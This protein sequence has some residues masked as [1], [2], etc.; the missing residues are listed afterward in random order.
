MHSA[1]PASCRRRRRAAAAGKSD[2][3]SGA[4]RRSCLSKCQPSSEDER[5]RRSSGSRAMA[6]GDGGKEERKED[7]REGEERLNKRDCLRALKEGF[8]LL[9]GYSRVTDIDGH[10]NT[11]NEDE[12]VRWSSDG[13]LAHGLR[14]AVTAGADDSG[15]PAAAALDDATLAIF[16]A[17]VVDCKTSRI[18]ITVE[19][20]VATVA[21]FG[22][23][24]RAA[25]QVSRQCRM[26]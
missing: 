26:D 4:T 5:A 22:M 24:S 15:E 14:L 8:L 7:K 18:S 19:H 13:A 23:F 12:R 21:P 9:P 25:A 16:D 3:G 20:L 17:A 6:R 11:S 1:I 2:T 10:Q